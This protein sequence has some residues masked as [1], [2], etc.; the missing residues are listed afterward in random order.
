MDEKNLMPGSFNGEWVQGEFIEVQVLSVSPLPGN[1]N[2]WADLPLEDE[3]LQNNLPPG[4]LLHLSP[5]D[6]TRLCLDLPPGDVTFLANPPPDDASLFR[7][8][9]PSGNVVLRVKQAPARDVLL[10]E[11]LPA[12]DVFLQANLPPGNVVCRYVCLGPV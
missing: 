5:G 9:L 6:E 4:D 11:N 2:L 12:G 3:V 10:W 7:I 8:N 1:V